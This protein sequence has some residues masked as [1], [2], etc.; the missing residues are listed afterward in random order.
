[1]SIQQHSVFL[2]RVSVS[3]DIYLAMNFMI[4]FFLSFVINVGFTNSVYVDKIT[5]A[6]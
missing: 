2:G 4:S 6:E 1:M 5:I 3:R